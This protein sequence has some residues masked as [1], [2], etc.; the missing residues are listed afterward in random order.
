MGVGPVRGKF[1]GS[2]T[3]RDPRPPERM[4]LEVEARGLP[5][6]VRGSG[7]LTLAEAEGGTTLH[8]AGEA[9]VTGALASVGSR[10]VGAAADRMM[11]QFFRAL[12]ERLRSRTG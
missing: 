1:T 3:V 2:V 6:G 5:G 9:R 8:C 10:V 12:E 4:T 11:E 7:T